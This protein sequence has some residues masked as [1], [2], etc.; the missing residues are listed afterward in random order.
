M[1]EQQLNEEFVSNW[2]GCCTAYTAEEEAKADA[3][4]EEEAEFQNDMDGYDSCSTTTTDSS[5]PS[6]EDC[7]WG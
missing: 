5:M 6:L 4:M 1:Q 3:E 7:T 2:A